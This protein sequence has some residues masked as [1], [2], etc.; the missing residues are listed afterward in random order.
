VLRN[1]ALDDEAK[2]LSDCGV[3]TG[4]HVRV[5]SKNSLLDEWNAIE[6]AVPSPA[7][8]RIAGQNLA[9]RSL[10]LVSSPDLNGSWV[11]APT[12]PFA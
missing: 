8:G 11:S 2:T 9:G 12:V 4:S 6:G 7:V 10:D 3:T 5:T 1:Q